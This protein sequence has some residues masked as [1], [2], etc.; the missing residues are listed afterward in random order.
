MVTLEQIMRADR[1]RG[2]GR[3]HETPLHYAT[4]LN[5]R[6][7]IEH[8][9]HLKLE[10]FQRTG[11][12]KVRGAAAKINALTAKERDEG[13]HRRVRRQPRTRRRARGAVARNEGAHRHAG[14]RSA[15][16]A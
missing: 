14:V 11:S 15:D 16:E 4:T 1:L 7:G 6:L 8:D 12:F 9:V 10:L 5:K 13:I 3:F 2:E